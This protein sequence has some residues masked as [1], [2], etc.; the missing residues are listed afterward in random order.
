MCLLWKTRVKDIVDHI[1]KEHPDKE[2]LSIN[3]VD[4]GQHF[5]SSTLHAHV[6]DCLKEKLKSTEKEKNLK[7]R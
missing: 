1:E 2:G 5:S 7:N 4:C 6:E 3:C